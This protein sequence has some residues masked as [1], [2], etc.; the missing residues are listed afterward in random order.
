MA[1]ILSTRPNTISS[2][3]RAMQ[4]IFFDI[5]RLAWH[6][7]RS[8]TYSGIQR[9][10]VMMIAETVNRVGAEHVF[11]SLYDTRKLRYRAISMRSIETET[12]IDARKF[13]S[14]LGMDVDED[15]VFPPLR[16]YASNRK[17]YSFHLARFHL[18]ALLRNN[19]FFR[20]RNVTIADW[21]SYLRAKRQTGKAIAGT[22]FASLASKGDHLILLDCS[23]ALAR[24]IPH[25]KKAHENGL[26]VHVM[27]YDLIPIV[28]P[29][30]V[31]EGAS[32][33]LYDWL[34]SSLDFTTGYLACSQATKTD[35]EAFQKAHNV[36][37]P[38]S[39]IP[40]AQNMVTAAPVVQA[41]GPLAERVNAEAY[42]RVLELVGVKDAIRSLLQM[43][44]VLCVGTLE[45]RKNNWRIA[46]AWDLLRKTV[47]IN[48]MPKLVFAG[49]SGWMN[50]DFNRLMVNTGQLDGFIS[51]IEAPSDAEL[52]LLYQN[53]S[54][55]ILASHYEGWG[56]PVGESLSYGKTAVVSNNSSLPEVGGD[57]VRYCDPLSPQSIM[58][59]CHDLIVDPSQREALEACIRATRL[60]TWA[61]VA[62]DMI[63]ATVRDKA[64]L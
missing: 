59:A 37:R 3:G 42:P 6:L 63:K 1:N 40:L 20:Q 44:Y 8:D 16:G 30:L 27:V 4:N 43:P 53:C 61:D 45:T 29:E 13:R 64:I 26:S 34:L 19:T 36:S 21:K 41:K 17:K 51:L 14:V 47:P 50:D 55:T 23:W 22:E 35:L 5:T 2:S 7:R 11:L 32:M 62:D 25:F 49:R 31:T 60:R 48:Q 24:S 33:Q 15:A 58:Q 39:L 46:L 10:A 9:A 38:V 12:L 56:L 57:L 18:N 28:R 52:A 54:F